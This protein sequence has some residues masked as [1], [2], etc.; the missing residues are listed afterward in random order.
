MLALG[1]IHM[2]M[3]IRQ[4]Y[5]KRVCETIS[6]NQVFYDIFKWFKPATPYGYVVANILC[7]VPGRSGIFKNYLAM[8][9]IRFFDMCF[10]RIA[11]SYIIHPKL[12]LQERKITKIPPYML[13]CV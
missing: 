5:V 7:I 11:E 6:V 9:L 13:V 8:S 3:G 4:V 2:G 12:F 1:I 10:G